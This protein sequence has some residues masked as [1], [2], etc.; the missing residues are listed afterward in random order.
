M[1]LFLTV[2][3][4]VYTFQPTAMQQVYKDDKKS[5]CYYMTFNGACQWNTLVQTNCPGT[6]ANRDVKCFYIEP[7]RRR[8]CHGNDRT[9]GIGRYTGCCWSPLEKPGSGPWC[10]H[11]AA[12]TGP[13]KP[14]YGC[15]IIR[16]LDKYAPSGYYYIMNNKKQAIR[17][18]CQM[19]DYEVN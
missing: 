3:V 4:L 2:L 18:Y 9:C 6:C 11:P 19:K 12:G 14:A 5:W 1:K 17:T 15:S 10:Y 16:A 13:N 7:R 8:D